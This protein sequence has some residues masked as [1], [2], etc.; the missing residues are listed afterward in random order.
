MQKNLKRKIQ[1][2]FRVDE[3]ELELIRK[4]MS[5]AKIQNKEMYYRKM[6]LDG[7]VVR[8][9]FSAVREMVKLLRNA[10]NNLNQIAKR[11]NADGSIFENDITDIQADYEK[12]WYQSEIIFN[13]IAETEF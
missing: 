8:V 2:I 11:V 13:K 4:K 10:T 5:A 12:L 6:V 1:Q 3:N 9:D 7:Y